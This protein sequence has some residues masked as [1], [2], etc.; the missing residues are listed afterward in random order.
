MWRVGTPAGSASADPAV[1]ASR[2]SPCPQLLPGRERGHHSQKSF[3]IRGF[4]QQPDEWVHCRTRANMSDDLKHL[5][6]HTA[7]RCGAL[8]APYGWVRW[9]V[10]APYAKR[11]DVILIDEAGKRL[12]CPMMA[13]HEAGYFSHTE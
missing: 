2:L 6:P 13:E 7:R 9:R 5:K 11:V 3:R 1:S 10:W 8:T 12:V 4:P